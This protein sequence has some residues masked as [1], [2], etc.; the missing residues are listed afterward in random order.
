[1][2]HTYL[3]IDSIKDWEA[4]YPSDN[5]LT[6]DQYLNG[7]YA[8]SNER[9]RV[10]N[11]C[12]T[13]KYLSTGYYCSLL[14]EARGHHVI[15]SV[16][17]L[18]DVERKSLFRIQLDDMLD[19][20]KSK[21]LKSL[22]QTR[23]FQFFSYFGTCEQVEFQEVARRVF[24][25]YPCPVIEIH[26]DCKDSWRISLVKPI[27]HT[28]LSETDETQFAKALE[29]FSRKIW[30]KAKRNKVYRYDLAILVDPKEPLPP[31]DKVAL[32]KF[33]EAAADLGIEVEIITP[34]DYQRL[35]EFDGLFIRSTT[36]IDH[37][38]Y[39]FAMKAESEG[40]VVIDDPTSIMRCT[41]KVYLADLFREFSVPAPKSAIIHP[42]QPL[43]KET[44]ENRFG[45]PLVMKIPDGAFSQGV[46]K[47]K[48]REEL[49]VSLKDLFRKSKLLLVQEF[50]YTDYDWRIGVLNNQP[51]FACRYYMVKN[52][53][54][55]YQ[56]GKKTKSGGFDC[57]AIGDVPKAVIQ[58]A[59]KATKPIGNG[60]YGVDV[61]EKDGKGYVIEVNDNPSIDSAVEDKYLGK[62][63]YYKI[64]EEFLRRMEMRRKTQ[65]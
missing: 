20:H 21:V 61:K 27:S 43:L 10:I 16:K 53:W 31:S 42:G 6:F 58:A 32:R 12:R 22:D 38:T 29:D 30:R 8:K 39:K 55:I 18:N 41:N 52:H 64:M 46:I 14:A 13:F 34:K 24:E 35:S 48:N 37:F 45:Y 40:L 63:L 17:T 54:Q 51:L 11:L 44:L 5:L 47:V 25:K 36:N 59:L 60:F 3:I 49:E 15:P 28:Q 57:V 19:D 4:Y 1:M 33:S 7:E 23:H 9:V 50:L 65:R 62:L 2:A 26:L 56:H